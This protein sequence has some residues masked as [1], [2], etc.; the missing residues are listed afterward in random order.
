M[1]GARC[2]ASGVLGARAHTSVPRWYC[3][4]SAANTTLCVC[5]RGSSAARESCADAGIKGRRALGDSGAL[6]GMGAAGMGAA[7]MYGDLAGG[8]GGMTQLEAMQYEAMQAGGGAAGLYGGGYPS[9][10]ALAMRPVRRLAMALVL[11]VLALLRLR[12]MLQQ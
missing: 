11:V 12:L 5:V 2:R 6:G 9:A 8:A 10:A 3:P 1:L 4:P 7:G